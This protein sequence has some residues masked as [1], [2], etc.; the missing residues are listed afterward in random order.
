MQKSS[1]KKLELSTV[2]IRPVAKRFNGRDGPRLPVMDDDWRIQ[3]VLE[4]GVGIQNTRTD[5]GT[6]LG[7]DHIHHW[8]SDPARGKRY[9]FLTLNVQIHIGG[10]HLWIEPTS[11]PGEPL[12]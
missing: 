8:T 7:Y 6:V 10:S 5:H 4:E 1:L 12:P 3:Q 9:G 11:R 2:R